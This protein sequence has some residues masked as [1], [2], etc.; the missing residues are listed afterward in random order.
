MVIP[1]T[2]PVFLTGI[3]ISDEDL[4]ETYDTDLYVELSVI[5]VEAGTIAINSTFGT[6]VYLCRVCR[7]IMRS[8]FFGECY[9]TKL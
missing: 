5:P 8:M 6:T 7:C 2:Q 4:L 3:V 1:Q 9:E